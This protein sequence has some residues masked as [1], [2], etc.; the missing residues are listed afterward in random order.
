[1]PVRLFS[2]AHLYR[3]GSLKWTGITRSKANP[4]IRAV[5]GRDGLGT[6]PGRRAMKRAIDD[7]LLGNPP[8]WN[9]PSRGRRG[10]S[11]RRFG[12]AVDESHVRLA[13]QSTPSARGHHRASRAARA[14]VVVPTPAYMP[15]CRFP[16]TAAVVGSRRLRGT[17]A[18]EAG[19]ST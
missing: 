14:P 18:G 16:Q 6:A 9:P 15:F 3:A 7:G 10:V 2:D 5:D 17:R 1:M 11:Q 8:G 13:S 4:T 12:W 19:R